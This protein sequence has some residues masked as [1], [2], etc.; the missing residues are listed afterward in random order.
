MLGNFGKSALI[1]FYRRHVM[2]KKSRW[3]KRRR[4]LR[5]EEDGDQV[6]TELGYFW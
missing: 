2:K 1:E 6:S 4:D 5:Q 3:K